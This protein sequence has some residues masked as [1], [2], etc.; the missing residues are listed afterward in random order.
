MSRDRLLSI[1][2][3]FLKDFQKEHVFKNIVF[4]RKCSEV[5]DRWSISESRMT[6]CITFLKGS[7]VEFDS[8]INKSQE[9]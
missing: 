4:S 3:T 6:T 2:I 7:D 5:L 8:E 1:C 9:S